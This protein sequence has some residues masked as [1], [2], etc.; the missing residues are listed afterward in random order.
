MTYDVYAMFTEGSYLVATSND[1]QHGADVAERVCKELNQWPMAF[2]TLTRG[3][4][5]IRGPIFSFN[6]LKK[7]G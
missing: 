2:A 1:Q 3:E 5:T 7:R 6:D 4:H